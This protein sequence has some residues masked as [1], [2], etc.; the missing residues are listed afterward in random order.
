MN[1]YEFKGGSGTASRLVR[2]AGDEHTPSA[3]S[4][5]PIS[6]RGGSSRSRACRS[7]SCWP[8]T[9]RWPTHA[10]A[11]RRGLGDRDRGHR[12]A[13]AAAPVPGA[14][15]PGHARPGPHRHHRLALLRRPV[16]GLLHRQPGRRSRSGA[17]ALR[18]GRRRA[19]TTSCG[20]SPGAPWTRSTPSVVQATEEA[21]ANALVAN[22]DMTGRDGHRSPALPR[23][24][25]AGLMRERGRSVQQLRVGAAL[26]AQDRAD[27]GDRV[28]ARWPAA[29]AAPPTPTTS[30]TTA[31]TGS[32]FRM[33]GGVGCTEPY[34]AAPNTTAPISGTTTCTSGFHR[35][36][37]RVR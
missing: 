4:F 32:S 26:L 7:A 5:R 22:E 3:C 35:R 18:R 37:S 30:Q 16:P 33:P 34:R 29:T 14:G 25:V 27:L 12:R 28:R 11:D 15:P 8:T 21:V 2:Y 17:A 36:E 6:A 13:A 19:A 24:R 20:S 9:T 31:S 23:D 1:C 10:H